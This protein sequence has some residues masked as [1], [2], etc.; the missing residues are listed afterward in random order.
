MAV[1]RSRRGPEPESREQRPSPA[2][3]GCLPP[4]HR[5]SCS[6]SLA[7]SIFKPYATIYHTRTLIR[8]SHR[9]LCGVP[10]TFIPCTPD[11]VAPIPPSNMHHEY[12]SR[13]HCRA[14]PNYLHDSKLYAYAS[15]TDLHEA[16]SL[17]SY[18]ISPTALQPSHN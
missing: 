16:P 9:F 6:H 8:L 17:E 3:R 1:R 15:R 4:R 13:S 12:Y 14:R 11:T 5:L 10:R 18:T 2:G 7:C